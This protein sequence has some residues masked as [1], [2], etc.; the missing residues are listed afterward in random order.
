MHV[1]ADASYNGTAFNLVAD[2]GSLT[3]LQDPAATSPWPVKLA[4]TVAGAKLAADGSLTQPLQGKGYNLAINGSVPDVAALAPLLQGS[5]PP[6]LHDVSFAAK[7]ADTGGRIPAF[8]TLALHVGASDLSAQVPGLTLDKLDVAA[9]AIDQPLKAD[10][11]GKLDGQP[12]AFAATTGPLA[13]L[14]PGAKPAPFPVDVT[15]QAAGATISAKG[16]IADA[17]AMT[18]ANIALAAQIPD[19]SALSPLARRP[20]P[21]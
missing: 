17:H 14:M 15:L 5:C 3:R 12:L 4:L 10:A 13:L 20:L 7:V 1:D 6:P 16:A 21:A 9:A 19:L 11:A 2:T 18:G 8:S